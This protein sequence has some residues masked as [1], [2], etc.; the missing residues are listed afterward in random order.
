M[1]GPTH[2]TDVTR[3]LAALLL[4]SATAVVPWSVATPAP[5]DAARA[6]DRPIRL[7]TAW[8]GVAFSP[9]G[10][11]SR[12]KARLG[13][14]LSRRADVL[15]KVRRS[16][17][18]H[19]LVHKDRL[20][21]LGRGEHTWTWD[22]LN[23]NGKRVAD[24]RY[25]VVLVA[26][27]VAPDGVKQNVFTSL[28]VDRTF[29]A[30]WSP[31]LTDDTVYPRTPGYPTDGVHGNLGNGSDDPMTALGK[32]RETLANPAGE[33]VRRLEPF[34]YQRSNN[35]GYASP[36]YVNGLDRSNDPLPAG[37]YT[38]TFSV[39]DPAGNA[40]GTKSLPLT[41]SDKPLVLASGSATLPP[42]QPFTAPPPGVASR[43]GDDPQPVPCGSVVPSQVYADPGAM[44]FRSSE[45]CGN[46]WDRPSIAT[47]GGAF[48]LSS[49][50]GADQAPRG[51]STSWVAMRG[52]PTV[53]GETDTAQLSTWGG[54]SASPT[55]TS[56]A[57]AGESVTTTSPIGYTFEAPYDTEYFRMFRWTIQT[58]GSDSYD[59]ASVTVYFTYL[60]PQ[61]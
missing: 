47:G 13:F 59:V 51:L 37:V 32:V 42:A 50:V 21:S 53:A 6:T 46:T 40:G 43:G 8:Y 20:D 25:I 17:G 27:Q 30:D 34:E 19:L 15:V 61:P 41:I 44:S 12:D 56:A 39:R 54:S 23:R 28:Y 33:V 45:A 35:Y 55:V 26:D 29:D 18:K 1:H 49:V 3:P 24:G 38:L 31:E 60:T 52:R 22:G 16:T 36:I 2:P 14:E 57:V 7:D 9:N 58:R 11:H 10:D 4:A 5:A 48:D